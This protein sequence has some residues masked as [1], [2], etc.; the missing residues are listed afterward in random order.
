MLPERAELEKILQNAGCPEEHRS[1]VMR[2]LEI[3]ASGNADRSARMSTLTYMQRLCNELLAH[4]I[5]PIG[6]E[7]AAFESAVLQFEQIVRRVYEDM[8]ARRSG[9]LTVEV[10]SA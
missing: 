2:S 10:D 7:W 8:D 4:G 3:V 9:R 5:P 1:S 6:V